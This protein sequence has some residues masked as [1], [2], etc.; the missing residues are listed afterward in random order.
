MAVAVCYTNESLQSQVNQTFNPHVGK[1][2]PLMKTFYRDRF[3]ES[4][5]LWLPHVF[6][7]FRHV[8][9]WNFGSVETQSMY[10]RSYKVSCLL[11]KPNAPFSYRYSSLLATTSTAEDPSARSPTLKSSMMSNSMYNEVRE[12]YIKAAQLAPHNNIDA[13]VQVRSLLSIIPYFFI[14][15]AEQFSSI[16]FKYLINWGFYTT[17]RNGEFSSIKFK[18][19]GHVT[20]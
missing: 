20:R 5:I 6:V 3:W 15:T 16:I 13:E 7:D 2:L 18:F 10:F 4:H 1:M 14:S 17:E 11:E 8:T 12:L 9:L 19:L